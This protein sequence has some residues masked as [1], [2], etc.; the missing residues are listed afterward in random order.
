MTGRA[1][2]PQ[3]DPKAGYLA[4]REEIDGA[5]RRV[6]ES[7]RYILGQ[8]VA[9]LEEEFAAYIG[10]RFGVGVSSGTDAL[11]LALRAC[12]VGPGDEVITVSH[13]AVATAVA[14]ELCGA[15]PVFVD[16]DPSTFVMDAGRLES[17][18]TP[19]T[20]AILPVH[21]YGH[22]ADMPS[23][24]SVAQ[25]HG[26]RIVEDCAQ[27]HGAAFDAV[28]S[29]GLGDIAAFSFYPTK[30]LGAYGDGG[31]VLTGVAALAERVRLLREYGWENR[32]SSAIPGFNSRLDEIQAAV[33]R[34]N[35][36]YLDQR[37]ESRRKKA[38]LFSRALEGAGVL[39]PVEKTPV[40]HV[41]HLYVI[42][43]ERRDSLQV[44]LREK[45]IGT[46]IHYPVP[47]HL[48][49][50]YK[51]L[52]YSRGALPAT[53]RCC[54]EILSLPL[55]PELAESDVER[56]AGDIREFMQLPRGGERRP[57]A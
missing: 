4:H 40:R 24:R 47:V 5:I 57:P 50:A 25:S 1:F 51:R 43:A 48:Q 29:G 12:G 23:I 2:I 33:L 37:N 42:R 7:G 49:P 20:R 3:A 46:L 41:Y 15:R 19:R 31:M 38:A 52:G 56:I 36:R 9:A 55:F 6:M 35:L 28:K 17:A 53:E 45:G 8:E 39:C 18:V 16:I 44:Y 11:H 13:T 21:L 32:Y 27:S 22:V 30:N 10:V 54:E 34:V 26:L 14:I